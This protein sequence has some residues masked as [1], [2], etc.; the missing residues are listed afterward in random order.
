MFAVHTVC[1]CVVWGQGESSKHHVFSRCLRF[2]DIPYSM[3][4]KGTFRTKPEKQL[5]SSTPPQSLLFTCFS[6][7]PLLSFGHHV[8]LISPNKSPVSYFPASEDSPDH[9]HS[10]VIH[11]SS[12][13]LRLKWK[14]GECSLSCCCCCC[15]CTESPP[16]KIVSHLHLPSDQIAS[17]VF[18]CIAELRCS[19]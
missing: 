19:P 8:L 12:V 1:L 15:C 7:P 6:V 5:L 9:P 3:T 4:L 2:Q 18:I 14:C 10:S 17:K 16:R 11:V 13:I